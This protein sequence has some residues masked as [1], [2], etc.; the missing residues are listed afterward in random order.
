MCQAALA[1]LQG[2]WATG[3]GCVLGVQ[4]LTF[5]PPCVDSCMCV[6]VCVCVFPCAHASMLLVCGLCAS[7]PSLDCN[8][9]RQ[10]IPHIPGMGG[11]VNYG[12][13]NRE[14]HSGEWWKAGGNG[15]AGASLGPSWYAPNILQ[16]ESGASHC[17]TSFAVCMQLRRRRVVLQ[18]ESL[19]Q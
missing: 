6:S 9:L 12:V 1:Q 4:W 13:Q 5:F 7:P 10:E 3:N 15:A 16:C 2:L 18:V 17:I 19:R 14:V 11:W 8:L